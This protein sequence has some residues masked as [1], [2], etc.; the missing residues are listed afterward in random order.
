MLKGGGGKIGG[1]DFSLQSKIRYLCDVNGGETVRI[2]NILRNSHI[3][4]IANFL[5]VIHASL[6]LNSAR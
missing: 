1:I 3:Y 5:W 6:L 2:I 4:L